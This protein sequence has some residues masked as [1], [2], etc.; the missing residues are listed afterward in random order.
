MMVVDRSIF[1]KVAVIEYVQYKWNI[2]NEN[3]QKDFRCLWN[4]N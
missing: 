3:K 1:L 2:M 4:G